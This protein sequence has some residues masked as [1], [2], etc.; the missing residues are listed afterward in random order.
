MVFY[1]D[2]MAWELKPYGHYAHEIEAALQQWSARELAEALANDDY[3]ANRRFRSYG[4]N[5]HW[6][7]EVT[8]KW[9][10]GR[11]GYYIKFLAHDQLV[12]ACMETLDRTNTTNNGGGVI[13]IDREGV[14]VV[15]LPQKH[16]D[17]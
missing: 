8:E 6:Y 14:S 10:N 12:D 16:G 9:F 11:V 17:E 3:A 2:V 7:R 4:R 15:E 5:S 1:T 13:W